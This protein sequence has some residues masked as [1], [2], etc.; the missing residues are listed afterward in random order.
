MIHV[1]GLD[2]VVPR[3]RAGPRRPHHHAQCEPAQPEGQP[4]APARGLP[5]V[6]AT[7]GNKQRSCQSTEGL[8]N[9]QHL[10]E[11]DLLFPL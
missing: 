2:Y 1:L 6:P 4:L 11:T 5:R 9:S 10:F 3:L 8:L 7:E